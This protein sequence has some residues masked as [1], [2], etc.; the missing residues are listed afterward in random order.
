MAVAPAA[1]VAV[2]SPEIVHVAPST[3]SESLTDWRVTGSQ[4]LGL[5]TVIVPLMTQAA[6]VWPIFVATTA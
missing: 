4:V 2:W 3:L 5:V 1:I 6:S